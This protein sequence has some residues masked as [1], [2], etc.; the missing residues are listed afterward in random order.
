M[1]EGTN[2]SDEIDHPAHYTRGTIEVWDFIINQGLPFCEGNIVKY[3]C[4]AGYKGDRLVDL[5][6]AKAYLDK[7]ISLEAG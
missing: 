5:K 1:I 6:K 3:V 7:L 2:M 4:R